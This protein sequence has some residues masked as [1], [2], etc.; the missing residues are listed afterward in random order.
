MS[1]N[2]EAYSYIHNQLREDKTL[3]KI[4]P[5]VSD[6]LNQTAEK[7]PPG[8]RLD[9]VQTEVT[10]FSKALDEK[11]SDY[12]PEKLDVMKNMV[13]GFLQL[14]Q[15][16]L[17]NKEQPDQY[18]KELSARISHNLVHHIHDASLEG[19]DPEF[20]DFMYKVLRNSESIAGKTSSEQLKLRLIGVKYELALTRALD[21]QG[22]NVYLPDYGQDIGDDDDMEVLQ[23][24]I[25]RGIDFVAASPLGDVFFIDSKS[26]SDEDV[27]VTDVARV[28]VVEGV[29]HPVVQNVIQKVMDDTKDKV[30]NSE[31]RRVLAATVHIPG[32]RGGRSFEAVSPLVQTTYEGKQ[33]FLSTYGKLKPEQE[34]VISSKLE[35][36]SDNYNSISRYKQYK[37]E[38]NDS[39]SNT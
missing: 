15:E 12:P 16:V 22:W 35:S 6:R 3:E 10:K 1:E 9:S 38:K 34:A 28:E 8:M 7:A 4:L 33:K 26:S 21:A 30:E 24:D 18:G 20:V 29:T 14:D 11:Y 17:N 13:F 37:T 5:E 23:L 19:A 31:D 2:L 32:S 39:I 27:S 25:K 36:I